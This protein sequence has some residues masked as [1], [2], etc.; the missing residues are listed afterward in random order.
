MQNFFMLLLI[1]ITINYSHRARNFAVFSRWFRAR[2]AVGV[3]LKRDEFSGVVAS[4]WRWL[5]G[6]ST[7]QKSNGKRQNFRHNITT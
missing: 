7:R 1:D 5:V 3:R 6:A 2:F 4:G